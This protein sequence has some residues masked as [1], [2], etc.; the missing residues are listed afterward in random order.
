MNYT[1]PE[2]TVSVCLD[3]VHT[4]FEDSPTKPTY[5]NGIELPFIPG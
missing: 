5:S 4:S 3:I 2:C 1:S